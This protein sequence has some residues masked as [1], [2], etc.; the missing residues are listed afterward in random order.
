MKLRI[1]S[2]LAIA[3]M[4]LLAAIGCRSEFDDNL[5]A[6]GRRVEYLEDSVFFT[7]KE[8]SINNQIRVLNQ[9]LTEFMENRAI[10]TVVENTDGSLTLTILNGNTL[11]VEPGNDGR[12]GNT[13]RDGADGTAPLIGVNQNPDD[14]H[15]YWT[16]NGEWMLNSD[17]EPIRADAYDGRNGTDGTDG[18]NGRDGTNGRDGADDLD[19]TINVPLVR[20]NPE[21]NDWE[22]STDGG[23]TWNNMGSSSNGRDGRNGSDGYIGKDGRDGVPDVFENVI[24]N[25]SS[26]TVTFVLTNGQTFTVSYVY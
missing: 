19:V 24:V 6:L 22:I 25:S 26:H 12:D 16:I 11:T 13:G 1:L 18:V 17:G 10:Q 7:N 4:V 9:I 14:G 15:W 8:T 21:T 2:Y 3:T 23:K 20:I 5:R